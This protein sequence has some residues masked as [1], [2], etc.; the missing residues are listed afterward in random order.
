MGR[1]IQVIR[2]DQLAGSAASGGMVRM[3]AVCAELA[4]SEGIFMGVSQVPAGLRSSG[5]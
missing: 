4:G 5:W 2:R 3:A 1:E